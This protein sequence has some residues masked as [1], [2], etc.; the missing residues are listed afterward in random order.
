[1]KIVN[2]GQNQDSKLGPKKSGV[3][4]FNPKLLNPKHGALYSND[5]QVSSKIC[6]RLLTIVKNTSNIKQTLEIPTF[7]AN[8]NEDIFEVLTQ[9]STEKKADS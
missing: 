3:I 4:S 1:M 9:A 6:Q 8:F 7:W 2:L 5:N